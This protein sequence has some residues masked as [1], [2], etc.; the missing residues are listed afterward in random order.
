MKSSGKSLIG[1][2][3]HRTE[4]IDKVTGCAVFVD[5]IQF[6]PSLLHSR[7]VRSPYPHA[8][9]KKVDP[10]KALAL[11]GVRAV[12]T[13]QDLTARLGLYL[14]DRPIFASDRVRY[15]GEPVAGVVATSEHIAVEAAKLVEV[16]YEVLPA[17]YNPVEAA[18]PDAPLLH[19]DLGE[20]TVANF[21]FPK[22]GTN[23]S[24]H[25][26]IRKGDT[27]ACWADCAAVAEGRFQL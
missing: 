17:I 10:K 3:V 8:L 25:F 9:I 1:Q 12:V 20:Y 11:P 21:I 14:I 7:L 19:P 15:Y 13:G 2:S 22:P 18:Q 4:V 16:E 5:D 26:K 6:G 23:I 24:E 27:D